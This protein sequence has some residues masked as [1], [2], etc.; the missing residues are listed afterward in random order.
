MAKITLRTRASPEQ[1]RRA[2]TLLPSVASGKARPA[3]ATE[4][5]RQ[6][7]HELLACVRESY[8]RKSAGGADESGSWA[9]L[10]PATVA[11]KKGQGIGRETG[12]LLASL[13]EDARPGRAAVETDVP[14][15][16]HFH[17]G[18]PLWP[19]GGIPDRWWRRVGS[20]ARAALAGVLGRMVGGS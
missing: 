9:P 4:L 16:G 17:A 20:A 2:V 5:Q 14:Y 11:R 13:R 6:I 8:L 12:R 7:A 10:S 18:R 15:A 1:V 3:D 19:Q